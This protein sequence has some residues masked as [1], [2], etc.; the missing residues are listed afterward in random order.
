MLAIFLVA[1]AGLHAQPCPALDPKFWLTDGPVYST[2]V[3]NDSIYLGGDFSYVGPRTGPAGLF[4]QATGALLGSPP[5]IS[6]VVRAIVPDGAG[7]WFIG[8]TFTRIGTV[9]ITNLARLNAD[10]SVDRRWN[11]AMVGTAVNALALDS[12]V[13]YVGG[14]FTRLGSRSISTLAGLASGNGAVVWDPVIGYGTVMTLDIANG[15]V[16]AGGTFYTVGISNRQNL[17][18]I[19]ITTALANAWNPNADQAVLTLKVSGQTVYVGGQFTAVGT[20]PRRSLAALDANGV[21]LNWN[22]NPNGIVRALALGG[23]SVYLGGDFTAVGG[24]NRPGFAAVNTGNGAAQ[25][26]DI[27]IQPASAPGGLVR[28]ILLDGDSLYVGGG[29]K[30]ALGESHRLLVGI[31]LLDTT[32]LPTPAGSE[33]VGAANAAFGINAMAA[34]NGKVLVGGEFVSIGGV[35]RQKAAA[36]SMSTG[37]A[38]PWAP[39]FS[40][41]V[42]SLAYSSNVVFA[43]GTFTN[44]NGVTQPGNLAA[45]D[46]V[47]GTSIPDFTFF[48][49]N[50]WGDASVN[51]LLFGSDRLYVAGAFTAVGDKGLRLLAAVNPR[52]GLVIDDFDAKLGGGYYGVSALALVSEKLYVA[53]D[54]TT[55]NSQPAARL[56]QVSADTGAMQS[57]TPNPNQPVN[58]LAATSDSIYV[59]GSFTS[60]A[61]VAFKN[62]AA[63]SIADNSV[64]G[65]DAALSVS[66][67]SVN[68]IAATPTALYV[69]GSFDS[70]GGEYRL[71]LA[72]LAC[73]NASSY[74]WDPAPE[75]PPATITLTD[76]LAIVGGPFRFLG[77]YPTNSPSGFLAVFPRGPWISGITSTPNN[78]VKVTTTTGDRIDAVLQATGDL[79]SPGWTNVA[80]NEAPGYS[81]TAEVPMNSPRQFIRAIAR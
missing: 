6:G 18:A 40:G 13:L 61:G 70:I 55:V 36:L 81:W 29:I 67:Q 24:Q 62:F 57:W 66:A 79:S 46:A 51:A 15:L 71:N 47:R 59:G 1:Q 28:S 32:V 26:L 14:A 9:S 77:R 37:A 74:E 78:T 33:Y 50:Q 56:A 53:G 75:L 21:A 73:F 16:Y 64:Q 7:G 25:S 3:A 10:L 42:R 80:T 17:A 34:A 38:L 69:S 22:P 19:D 65:V 39:L 60:I 76:E 43:G 63:F 44:V 49:T 4:H 41:P 11:A 52:S 58:T 45:V 68:A 8:G 30:E 2:L 27:K 12:G 23:N 54:F 48:G 20:K 35:P 5:S 31:S 72:C